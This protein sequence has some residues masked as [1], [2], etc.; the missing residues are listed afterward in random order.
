MNIFYSKFVCVSSR[1]IIF[2]IFIVVVATLE[3]QCPNDVIR[4]ANHFVYPIRQPVHNNIIIFFNHQNGVVCFIIVTCCCKTFSKI[5]VSNG[6][7]KVIRINVIVSFIC[8]N[9][10]G[11]PYNVWTTWFSNWFHSTLP[12]FI[13]FVSGLFN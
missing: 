8:C 11:N 2:I 12:F 10:I 1:G 13:T 5:C 9:L 4:G 3:G 7:L 6:R